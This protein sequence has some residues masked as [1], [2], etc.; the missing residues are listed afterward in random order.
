MA[1]YGTG[2]DAGP[3][4]GREHDPALP[5]GRY[6]RLRLS[7]GRHPSDLIRMAVAAAVVLAC[8]LFAESR[9]INPVEAAIAVQM[10][11][12]SLW[13]PQGWVVATWLGWWPGV[14]AAVALALYLGRMRV[15]LALALAGA[16]SWLLAMV[17]Q[18]TL[19]PRPI[20]PDLLHGPGAGGFDFPDVRSAVIAA[21]ASV[22]AP[23]LGRFSRNGS[24]LLV[25]LVAT[26]NVVLGRNLPLGAF[27]G[28]VLGWGTGAAFH[29]LVGAP[30][31]RATESAVQLALRQAGIEGALVVPRRRR[32]LR[33][34]LYDLTTAEGERL[35]MKIVNRL[36]RR[37]G[38]AHQLRRLLASLDVEHDP[39][40]ATPRHEV[41]HEAYV[42][43]LA[44]RAGV[45]T[46]PVVFAGEIEHG[47]PYLIR[48]RVEGR[49]LSELTA[50]EV[51][52]ETLDQIWAAVHILA[53]AHIAH[54][55]LRAR[56]ILIDLDGRPHIIDFTFSRVGGPVERRR[57]DA[58]ELLVS[59]AG[60]VGNNRAVASVVRCVPPARLRGALPYLQRLALRPQFRR[61]LPGGQEGLSTLRE[62][63]AERIGEPPPSFRLP[64][65]PGT[66]L[67]LLVGGLAVYLMLPELASI[68]HVLALVR[69]GNPVWLI[70]TL[71]TGL[72]AI[73]AS[74]VSV[75]GSSPQRLPAGRTTAVQFAAAF[76]GRT[77]AAGIGFYRIN[78]VFLERIGFPGS[79]SVAI[80]GINRVVSGLVGAVGTAL[81]ILVIGTAV[82]FDKVQIPVGWPV[83]AGAGALVAAVVVFLASPLG[84]R[85]LVRP[86]IV[87]AREIGAELL[88]LLRQPRRAAQL[89]GGC[90]GYLLLSAAGLATTL[91]AFTP[92]FAL[93]PVL[94]VYVVGT[95]LGQ[96][97][98]TPGGL[99][100]VEAAT[101]AGLTAIGVPSTDAVAAVLTARLLTYWFPVLPGIAV[102]R[103]LQYR[104]VV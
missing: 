16:A 59:L 3:N 24:A 37:A 9:L 48:R 23:F 22:A 53:T 73:L 82:P 67:V 71:V 95:T 14:A 85:R 20:P 6:A 17:V 77:T 50:D 83:L 28:A 89:V 35:E 90:I 97:A 52:E 86:G 56:N 104:G 65:R 70:A 15:A 39:R 57:Q 10:Q 49:K 34:E 45:G 19:P 2:G 74:A 87:R 42:T 80:I 43:L 68:D 64:V 84:R 25:L 41:E 69:A 13:L 31:R 76:T 79:R 8:R 5:T 75:L 94:A 29:L 62:T 32:L 98:P 18:W 21:L 66:V 4:S 102:F 36:H 38:A 44:E 61:Q 100:A 78:W 96:L 46:L 11:G 60:I 54:H 88:P 26:A 91:A 51:A 99:G 33:P 63:L 30:G 55:D 72:L 101:I 81:G 93:L 27:A 103:I 12:L 47:P 1:T 58:A 7:I 40:L 92:G